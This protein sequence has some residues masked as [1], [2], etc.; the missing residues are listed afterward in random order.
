M[1]KYYILIILTIIFISGCSI[2]DDLPGITWIDEPQSVSFNDMDMDIGQ[3]G[4][5]V[6]IIRA[7][8]E[9]NIQYYCIYLGTAENNKE[10][11]LG[12]MPLTG[13]DIAF[14]LPVNT[15]IGN[16]T[17]LVVYTRNDE[18]VSS[19]CVET[20]I[21][22]NQGDPPANYATNISFIDTDPD[23]WEI[24]G[25]IIIQRAEV[26]SDVTAYC[27]YYI[28]S[29]DTFDK[30]VELE[31]NGYDLSYTIPDNT[32]LGDH[33]SLVVRTKNSIQEMLDG[34]YCDITDITGVVPSNMAKSL[35]FTDTNG[36]EHVIS[37]NV[38]I[39]K[40]DNETDITHYCLYWGIDENTIYGSVIAELPKENI[41]FS[42][43][44]KIVP[45]DVTH[46]IV[47]TKN[48][49][50]VMDNGVACTSI[51]LVGV[52]PSNMAKSI[53]F[54]DT[55]GDENI[56]SGNV[57]IEKADNETDITHY[58][59]YW[60]IDENTIY[61]SAIAELPKENTNYYLGN[62]DIS[63]GISYFIVKT[64]NNYGEMKNGISVKIND[65]LEPI[66]SLV[67]N[68]DDPNYMTVFNNK[69][70]FK[71][72]VN[73]YGDELFS[74]DC[75]SVDLVSDINPGSASGYPTCLTEYN[76]RLYF[77]A[78]DGV[79]GSELWCFDGNNTYMVADINMGSYGSTI[80]NM[81]SYNNKLYFTANDGIHG[82]ELW[83][84][85]GNNTYMVMDIR[86]G[87][88]D[89]IYDYCYFSLYNNRLYFA[90]N[91]GIHG[92]E[93]W[94]YDG[95]NTYM[96]ADINPGSNHSAPRHL[97]VYNNKLYFGAYETIFGDELWCHD[98]INTYRITNTNYQSKPF[99]L[100]VYNNR[101]YFSANDGTHG[102][103]LWCYDGNNTY[104][105]E[106]IR[107][108][109]N[110]SFPEYLLVY[111]DKLFFQGTND[112]YGQEL[113]CFDSTITK[114]IVD[115]NIGINNSS[116]SS[117]VV[118]NDKIYFN[119]NNGASGN[120]LWSYED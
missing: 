71:A 6:T 94:C 113:W 75:S 5:I 97:T 12:E 78:I 34:T 46:L 40:A 87:A 44:N 24:G 64:K 13:G 19:L 74:F 3:I 66:L 92:V 14:Y 7:K 83:C 8:D 23:K 102:I 50:G 48:Y 55:N 82:V 18:R 25:D 9:Y 72:H 101:L 99:N 106:D 103:E 43:D 54:T 56:I 4:G 84:F 81:A 51:D 77:E 73:G 45:D 91:D 39:E 79:H 37:G 108:G 42:F 47:K 109:I 100:I 58:C 2:T 53:S 60:G 96:V 86:P 28:N 120:V 67:N 15:L 112:I 116:P 38:I 31:K 98:G 85:D 49:Y 119:A 63:N 111:N 10:K 110:G 117:L 27:I 68:I 52:V 105:V 104:M 115:I 107:P 11:L 20:I 61:G 59:L 76:N 57:F 93:L 69:L 30:I 21:K 65:K 114:L 29:N 90:A 17:K 95:I 16:Y 41:A 33:R 62:I 32:L 118:Y 70:Y 26:E 36:D 89:S 88:D 35:S 1:L 22:D 80:C